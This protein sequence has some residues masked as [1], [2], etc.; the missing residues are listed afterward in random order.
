MTSSTNMLEFDPNM[1]MMQLK[2][3]VKQ[4]ESLLSTPVR[5]Q[6]DV[7]VVSCAAGLSGELAEPA[8]TITTIGYEYH[9]CQ[10]V[11]CF[12]MCTGISRLMSDIELISI[13]KELLPFCQRYIPAVW[14]KFRM[15]LKKKPDYQ[16]SWLQV[17]NA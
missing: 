17:Y 2:Y 16:L 7:S 6:P 3:Q 4:I 14:H 11:M 1:N 15:A 9:W 12:T 10:Q 13:N 8:T 5:L